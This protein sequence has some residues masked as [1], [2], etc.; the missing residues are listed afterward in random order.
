[1]AFSFTDLLH[2]AMPARGDKNWDA[3]VNRALRTIDKALEDLGARPRFFD[4]RTVSPGTAT[5]TGRQVALSGIEAVVGQTNT[6]LDSGTVTVPANA[7]TKP[8]MDVLSVNPEQPAILVLTQGDPAG[9]IDGAL[10]VTKMY[11]RNTSGLEELLNPTGKTGTLFAIPTLLAHYDP[12]NETLI[13]PAY[14]LPLQMFMQG[15]PDSVIPKILRFDPAVDSFTDTGVDLHFTSAFRSN[16]GDLIAVIPLGCVAPNAAGTGDSYFFACVVSNDSIPGNVII[17]EFDAETGAVVDAFWFSNEDNN[18]FFSI[19][20]FWKFTGVESGARTFLASILP[21]TMQL[22]F[23][24]PVMASVRIPNPPSAVKMFGQPLTFGSITI[25]AM[26]IAADSVRALSPKGDLVALPGSGMDGSGVLISGASSSEEGLVS[27]I[28]QKRNNSNE[29]R[30]SNS[31]QGDIGGS[32]DGNGFDPFPIILELAGNAAAWNLNA[33]PVSPSFVSSV[34]VMNGDQIAMASRINNYRTEWRNP[35]NTQIEVVLND[36]HTT[37]PIGKEIF[38]AIDGNQDN[39]EYDTMWSV[40]VQTLPGDGKTGVVLNNAHIFRGGTISDYYRLSGLQNNG[41]MKIRAGYRIMNG[42]NHTE[43]VLHLDGVADADVGKPVKITYD[44]DGLEL[45]CISFICD[46]GE[47]RECYAGSDNL[48]DHVNNEFPDWLGTVY[49]E[50]CKGDIHIGWNILNSNNSKSM[51]LAQEFT[52]VIKSRTEN[53]VAFQKNN[54]VGA[55]GSSNTVTYDK[56]GVT[57]SWQDTDGGNDVFICNDTTLI[58]SSGLPVL[59]GGG[60]DYTALDADGFRC[61]VGTDVPLLTSDVIDPAYVTVELLPYQEPLFSGR[62]YH[63]P[64]AIAVALGSAYLK[65]KFYAPGIALSGI[66]YSAIFE[67]SPYDEP[68]A[69]DAPSGHIKVGEVLVPPD[70]DVAPLSILT[71]PDY[72][73]ATVSR[74]DQFRSM[75]AAFSVMNDLH[76]LL[77]A[78][79]TIAP[80]LKK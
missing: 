44:H 18:V 76:N 69:Q 47:I 80:F 75:L 25:H 20:G 77:P 52:P 61:A 19:P 39:T 31:L 56:N 51:P 41:G 53:Y 3:D 15:P 78:F 26:E 9:D 36:G 73:E 57:A 14:E 55:P 23:A 33:A 49:R 58:T 8:R 46:D 64:S 54:T 60:T 42:N 7:T 65:G 10:R 27:A 71:G 29:T 16:V 17:A 6:I 13:A 72:S 50:T 40:V 5:V 68:V 37:P 2:L 59:G 24:K 62:R 1:M 12:A 63:F 28:F 22:K 79:L 35:T 4:K 32:D 66:P 70:A 38:L 34:S 30:P 45:S 74:A 67:F 11:D 48:R 21:L 43:R